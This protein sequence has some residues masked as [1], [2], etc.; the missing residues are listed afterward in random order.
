MKKTLAIILA[1]CFLFMTAFS[2]YA[3]DAASPVPHI[4]NLSVEVDEA[5]KTNVRFTATID[6]RP[7]TLKELSD[8]TVDF[9]TGSSILCVYPNQYLGSSAIDEKGVAVFSTWQNPGQY[10]GGAILR[11]KA[12]G[13]IYSNV[14]NYE[15][16]SLS[17][18][19]KVT[20]EVISGI[21]GNINNNVN[22]DAKLVLPEND[23]ELQKP[24]KPLK[25]D[26]FIGNPLVDMYPSTLVGSADLIDCEAKLSVP[27]SPGDYAGGAVLTY[28]DGGMLYATQ[29]YFNVPKVGLT[30]TLKT[31][32]DSSKKS[33][34]T[35][36]VCVRVDSYSLTDQA[37]SWPTGPVKVDFY[38]SNLK[39]Y[40]PFKLVG[41]SYT[42]RSGYA[43]L[44]FSQS[45]G[46]YM[47]MAK[48]ETKPYGTF[49][50]E[51]IKYK[52]APQSVPIFRQVWQL[53]L[54]AL[55]IRVSDSVM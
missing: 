28:A 13:D 20:A 54:K 53:F 45:Q 5:C 15:V 7:M 22:F 3:S 23:I 43:S 1:S 18:V 14:F 29:I 52:V 12:F 9:Y 55:G 17:P 42:N 38:S 16:K 46:E 8:V 33:N 26:F 47:A 44:S 34:V 4:L 39:E 11:S 30:M 27:V 32:V 10:A 25:V 50:S 2:A 19:L 36:T 40:T 24:I 48:I 51:I 31:A 6:D 35:Y 21:S 37:Q 41:S 49:K